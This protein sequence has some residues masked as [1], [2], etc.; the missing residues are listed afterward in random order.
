[1]RI[2]S[3]PIA[4]REEID[5]LNAR[6]YDRVNNGVYKAGFATTQD[7]YESA[8]YPLFAMLDELEERL[9]G[10]RYL[11]GNMQTE[12]DWRLFTT[13]LRFDPVYHG[14]FKCN[15][16]RLV[17]YPNLWPYTRELYQWPGVAETVDFTHIKGHYYRSH[18]SINPTG[19][20]PLGPLL[21]LAAPHGRAA[22]A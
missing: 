4:L 16:R 15:L 11:F 22:R 3:S 14:H 6:V 17:D 2:G 19:I 12:A 18:V 13:L 8:V 5:A 10:Q 21:D 1:M 7:A 20:V 9:S